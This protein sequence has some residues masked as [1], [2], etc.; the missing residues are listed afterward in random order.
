MKGKNL[1]NLDQSIYFGLNILQ[2]LSE[3]LERAGTRVNDGVLAQ[4]FYKGG[5]HGGYAYS[6]YGPVRA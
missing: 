3:Y 2:A 5:V 1:M 4:S 6:T